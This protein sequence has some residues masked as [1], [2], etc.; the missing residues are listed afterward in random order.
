MSVV[1]PLFNKAT[2]VE[3]TVRSILAQTFADFEVIVVD[4][5]STDGS[6]E[7]VETSFPDPRIRVLR[8]PN[9]GPGAARNHG[10]R[11]GRGDLV[12]FLDADDEWRPDFLDRA[13]TIL[14]QHPL[15]GAFT[16]AYYREPEG[17]N[18]WAELP[19]YEGPWRLTP[20][21]QPAEL[22]SCVDAFH[23]TTAVYRRRIFEAYDGFYTKNRCTFGEDVVLWLRILLNEAI[24][25][26]LEPLAHYHL[27]DSQLGIGG[28][29]GALPLEPVLTDPD[30]VRSRC[31]T[32]LADVLELWL[33]QQ[34]ARAAF[35]QLDRGDRK[36]AAWLLEA[37]PGIKV[38][39]STYIK[40]RLRLMAPQLWIY[41]RGVTRTI[42]KQ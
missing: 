4:D 34:A 25:R 16:A 32:E 8:Q 17:V 36:N 14:A 39:R 21:V 38:L 20:E 3:R 31:P 26:H 9:A 37:F 42:W 1:V 35:M 5:G 40:L 29:K 27:E 7:L 13:V 22:S 41:L 18:R 33:A 2:T 24:Y 11:V 12:T 6:A 19:F 23:P 30:C 28:R 15:C 10:A